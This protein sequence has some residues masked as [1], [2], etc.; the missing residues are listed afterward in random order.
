MAVQ[1]IVDGKAEV[2]MVVFGLSIHFSTVKII[3]TFC[4]IF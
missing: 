2:E 4:N 3:F 1:S